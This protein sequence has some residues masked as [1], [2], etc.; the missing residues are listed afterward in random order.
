MIKTD[1]ELVVISI[2]HPEWAGVFKIALSDVQIAQDDE[3]ILTLSYNPEKGKRELSIA[4]FTKPVEKQIQ[5]LSGK[6]IRTQTYEPDFQRFN[7][8]LIQTGYVTVEEIEQYSSREARKCLPLVRTTFIDRA[9]ENPGIDSGDESAHQV[10]R[11][12]KA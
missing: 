11:R 9:R 10:G 3:G 12:R 6:T 4:D 7:Q 2:T 8:T 5:L 1:N